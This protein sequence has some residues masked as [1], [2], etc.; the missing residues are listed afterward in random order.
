MAKKRSK[1]PP[2][3]KVP[4]PAC[5]ALLLCD[6]TII[7][8]GS[9]KVSI[10]GSFTNFILPSFPGRTLPFTAFVQLADGI[11]RYEIQ[12][13]IHD[14]RDDMVL[15]RS[16]KMMIEFAERLTKINI[17][18]PVPPL[19]LAHAGKYDVVFLA[20]GQEI[21]RQQFSAISPEGAENAEEDDAT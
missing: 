21:D 16:P 12:V 9:G 8:A 3:G 13:E 6:H 15:A 11:G 10:I 2:K 14:L 1:K 18:L 4:P 17:C 19:P 20:K 7:E 5:K